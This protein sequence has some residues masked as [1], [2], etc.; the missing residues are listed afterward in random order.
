[1]LSRPRIGLLTGPIGVGKTTIAQRV[2]ELARQQGLVCGGIL[3]P[4]ITDHRGQKIGVY[5]IDLR[6]GERRTLARTDRDLGGPSVGVYSFDGEA[7]AWTVRV[8]EQALDPCTTLPCDLVI[9][10]EIGKLEL[11]Q[12]VGLA[13]ILPRLSTLR[14]PWVLVL[15]RDFLL[16][17][18][19]T[20]LGPGE[21][22]VFWASEENR[23]EMPTR[24]VNSFWPPH[25]E[26]RTD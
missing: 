7:L 19:Q 20:R 23:E 16:A 22:L 11:W 2:V 18:L 14:R 9:V 8:V 10:D 1:M 12:G 3:A 4:G 15:V 5:G 21:R 13:P 6:T 17:E 26:A 24:I 25:P